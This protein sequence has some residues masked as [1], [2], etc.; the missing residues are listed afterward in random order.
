VTTPPRDDAGPNAIR[1]A[2][3]SVHQPFAEADGNLARVRLPGGVLTARG[4]HAL[5]GAVE[6]VGGS[7]I[8]L[9]NRANLQVRGVREGSTMQLRDLLVEAELV[10]PDPDLDQRRNV[11]ASPTSGIDAGELVDARPHVAAVLRCLTAPAPAAAPR[12]PKFGVLVDGGGLVHVRDRAHDVALGAVRDATGS[13]VF[14]VR[15]AGA[16]RGRA[17]D[18]RRASCWVVEPDAVHR[19]VEAVVTLTGEFGRVSVL[20][21][22]LGDAAVYAE[23]AARIDGMTERAPDDLERPIGDSASPVGTRPQRQPGRMSVGATVPLGRITASALHAVADAADAVGAADLRISPWRQL[24]VTG[25]GA[26]DAHAVVHELEALGLVV[27][28][29]HPAGAVVACVGSRGCASGF[30]DTLADA[31]ALIA[32]LADEPACA[33]PRS[34]HVSGCEKGCAYPGRADVS[35]VAVAGGAYA[36]HRPDATAGA[37]DDVE[38]R[39]GRRVH[40]GL[41]PS[42]ARDAVIDIG[43]ARAPRADDDES[44]G[45]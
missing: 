12:S 24:I 27:D 37:L 38:R 1:G 43:R 18:R 13:T 22:Q 40:A 28:P 35:L 6:T 41:L 45:A 4:A 7:V 30:T 10:D 16:L 42:A 8:E 11:L 25:V 21:D 14:E 17:T 33:R 2:C 29:A 44:V 23:L 3:P 9:T 39:F 5:A 36:L 19:L 32:Q 15:L 26:A 34:V 31:E 20:L